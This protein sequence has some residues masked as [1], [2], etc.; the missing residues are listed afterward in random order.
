LVAH[1]TFCTTGYAN[2]V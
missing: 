1:C 2:G